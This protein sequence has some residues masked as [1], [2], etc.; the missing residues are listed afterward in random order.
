[1]GQHIWFHKDQN[2]LK[3][4]VEL[5]KKVDAHENGE[6]WLDDLELYQIE[7]E[8]REITINNEA[9]YH[10]LFR[11]HKRNVDGTYTDDVIYSKEECDQW[12]KDNEHLVTWSYE[13]EYRKLLNEFWEKYPNGAI[14]F[15]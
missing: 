9:D 7:Q 8:L 13:K 12:L 15:V 6:I 1:M 4:E 2:L 11:T 14:N 5:Y 10:D 3:K